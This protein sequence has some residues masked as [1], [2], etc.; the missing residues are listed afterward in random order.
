MQSKSKGKAVI[1]LY[2]QVGN[3]PV[4]QTNL[5]CYCDEEQF[6]EQMSFLNDS[7]YKVIGLDEL[8]YKISSTEGFLDENYV[9][10]TFDDGCDQFSKKVLPIL[11]KYNF[12]ATLYPVTGCLGRIA[13]WPKIMNPGLKIITK[14]ALKRVAK[15]G[16]NIGAHTENHVKLPS[17]DFDVAREEIN[18]S[19]RLLEALL[20]RKVT[21]FSYP[22]GDYNKELIALVKSLGFSNAVTCNASAVESNTNLFELPRKYVTY[23]DTIESFKKIIAYGHP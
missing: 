10:L 23:F 1:L 13:S 15:Q 17:C 8:V 16:V 5:D 22:H 20:G 18:G 12:P 21:S 9:V 3:S 7:T 14:T 2:H 6:E 11:K 4:E 19:K